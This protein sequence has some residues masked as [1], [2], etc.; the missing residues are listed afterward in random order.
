[1]IFINLIKINYLEPL[2][3][4][5]DCYYYYFFFHDEIVHQ[6]AIIYLVKV[7]RIVIYNGHIKYKYIIA[8]YYIIV[9]ILFIKC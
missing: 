2:Y 8:M 6:H 7:K 1:M 9:I 3:C 5:D 4:S